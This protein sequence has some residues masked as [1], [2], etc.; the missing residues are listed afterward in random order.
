MA[1]DGHRSDDF[2]I[3]L[4]KTTDFGE[5]WKAITNGIPKNSGTLHVI[6]EHPRNRDLLFAGGE[7]GLYISFDRGENWQELKNNLPRVPVDDIQIHPRDNDLIL[8]T[9]G[10]SVWILDSIYGLEQMTAK[11][12]GQPCRHFDVRPAIMWR[13][14]RKRDFDAHDVF[15]RARIRRQG[16]IIDF[17]VQDQAGC[18]GREDHDSR[19]GGQADRDAQADSV[20]G[21]SESRRVEPACG[22][23][24][25]AHAAGRGAG[26]RALRRRA[27]SLRSWAARWSI[28]ARYTVEISIGAD[29][30]R[31]SSR[32]EEDPRITWFSAAD[33]AKAA[34]GDRRTGRR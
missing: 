10:R 7:F 26:R 32:V 23:A 27:A 20:G 1:F 19:R 16:A 4:F 5:T 6:R 29:K 25:A 3:Y 30:D 9:H 12:V 31:R 14:A 28:R 21:G 2:N 22:P 18:E 17:W 13:M 8:A 33:R 24:G 11:T 34:G 15:R